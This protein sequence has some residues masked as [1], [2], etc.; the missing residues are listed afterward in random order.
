MSCGRKLMRAA[1]LVGL[2][3][4]L[5]IAV[6]WLLRVP[7]L[8]LAGQLLMEDDGPRKADAILVLGGDDFGTRIIKAAQLA[9]Q[10]YA[11]DV[12]VSTPPS[13]MGCNSGVTIDFAESKGYP[14]SLFHPIPLPPGTDSTRSEATFLGNYLR[15]HAINRILLVTSNYH[16][17]RAAR[18]WRTQAPWI[19]ITVVA[20][21][22]PYFTPGGWWK[23]RSGQ[24]TFLLEWTKTVSAWLGD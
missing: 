14:G 1:G 20:A 13:L 21:P 22:D 15:A 16:T 23:V 24:K 19:N 10:G 2:A 8:T 6:L 4:V 5:L 9:K 17:R 12:L 3:L 11:A 7:L 18:L